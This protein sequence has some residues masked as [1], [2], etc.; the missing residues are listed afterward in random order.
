MRRRSRHSGV[1]HRR[2]AP[3]CGD[4]VESA[5]LPVHPHLGVAGDTAR[6]KYQVMLMIHLVAG[7]NNPSDE[8]AEGMVSRDRRLGSSDE[9]AG[10]PSGCAMTQG[11][12]YRMG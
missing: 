10:P 5:P 7:A 1:S 2:R 4:F 11:I 6:D 12:H 8:V 3:P 9:A